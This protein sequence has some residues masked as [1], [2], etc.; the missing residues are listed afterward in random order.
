MF[1][2]ISFLSGVLEDKTECVQISHPSCQAPP[3]LNSFIPGYK[4]NP[5]HLG[6]RPENYN[7]SLV[8]KTLA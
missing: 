7:V 8:K 1:E 6:Y 4:G 2:Y 3:I 5:K